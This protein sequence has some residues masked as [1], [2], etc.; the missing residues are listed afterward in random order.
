MKSV[1]RKEMAR[2]FWV[3]VT[4]GAVP[5]RDVEGL[6]AMIDDDDDDPIAEAFCRGLE[7]EF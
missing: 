5:R 7:T 1:L 6:R 2:L 4:K 3:L